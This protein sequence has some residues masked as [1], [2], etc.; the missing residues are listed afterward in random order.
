M[1]YL[2]LEFLCSPEQLRIISGI[3]INYHKYLIDKQMGF[4]GTPLNDSLKD[5]MFFNE[6]YYLADDTKKLKFFIDESDD[7][8]NVTFDKSYLMSDL[9]E[10]ANHLKKCSMDD[11]KKEIIKNINA[12]F[13]MAENMDCE[14]RSKWLFEIFRGDL[15]YDYMVRDLE[16]LLK[17]NTDVYIRIKNYYEHDEKIERTLMIKEEK[18]IKFA[19]KLN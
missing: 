4:F 9:P 14:E 2:N 10:D 19:G 11:T 16:M 13:E 12:S 18:L 5:N 8:L 6:N 7:S 17:C 1:I 15:I 3:R